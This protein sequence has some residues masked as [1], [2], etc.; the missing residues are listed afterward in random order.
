MIS[1]LRQRKYWTPILSPPLAGQILTESEAKLEWAAVSTQSLG[2]FGKKDRGLENC[3]SFSL[4]TSHLL[5]GAQEQRQ[6]LLGAAYR[7]LLQSLSLYIA[8]SAGLQTS[9]VWFLSCVESRCPESHWEQNWER[10][11]LWPGLNSAAGKSASQL[12]HGLWVGQ[13]GNDPMCFI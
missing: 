7:T 8:H 10:S 11:G 4:N 13:R 2:E 5:Y 12:A 3:G 6:A 9:H 1:L